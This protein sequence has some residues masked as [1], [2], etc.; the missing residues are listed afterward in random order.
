MNVLTRITKPKPS[1]AGLK[2]VLVQ[3]S[4]LLLWGCGG[5]SGIDIGSGQSADAVVL[6]YPLFYVKRPVSVDETGQQIQPD[7]RELLSVEFGADLF[8][9]ERA[10]V[11]APEINLSSTI[12]EELHDVRDISVSH[13]GNLVL[14]S[15]R[16]PVDP[17][18]DE[19]DQPAWNIWEYDVQ[20]RSM[21]RIM[22]DDITA[23][24]GHDIGAQ[25]LPNGR[26]VF[27]STRQN[28]SVAR[29]TDQGKPQFAAL[30]EDQN[31]PAFVLHVMDADGTNIE[32]ISFNQSHDS[33][34]TVLDNG[35]I[36][37]SR[38]DGMGNRS[39]V[40]L[41]TANPDGTDL[42]LLYG[43]DSHETASDGMIQ[44]L[45]PKELPD[46]RVLSL[47]A[48]FSG[49]GGG[50][51]LVI[52]DVADYL[53]NTQPNKFNAGATGPAERPATNQ[54]VFVMP[55]VS[56]GG[57]FLSA[58]P[59]W[60]GTSRALISYS[61]CRVRVPPATDAEICDET[62]ILDPL[63]EDAIPAYG[64]WVVDLA[65][66]SIS[67]ILQP[68]DGFTISHIA[69]AQNRPRQ[70]DILDQDASGLSDPMLS[71]ERAGILQIRSVYDFDGSDPFGYAALA[72][73]AITNANERPARFIRI[74]SAV[75]IPDED[76]LDLDNSAF[77]I[78]RA[79]GMRE[80]IGYAPI[81]PDGS[82][83]VKVPADVPIS[84]DVL[85]AR[86]KRIFPFARH[87]NWLQLRPGE[88]RECSG[89]H[90]PGLPGI[91]HG[92]SDAFD[93]VNVGAPVTGYVFPN[94]ALGTSAELGET[95]AANRL[96]QS[97]FTDCAVR[98]LTANLVYQDVWTA[99][100]L[101]PATSFELGYDGLSVAG[102]SV[103]PGL[104]T[105]VPERSDCV[106]WTVDCRITINY[107]QHIQPLWELERAA[108][109]PD[110]ASTVNRCID[111]H[112]LRDRGGLLIDP[113]TGRGQLELTRNASDQDPNHF[114]SYRELLSADNQELLSGDT[115]AVQD[116]LADALD[117]DG[118]PVLEPV[119]I[120]SPLSV[121]GA[122]ATPEFFSRFTEPGSH[123]GYLSAAELHLITEWLDLGAQYF[124]DPF[125]EGVPVN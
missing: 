36:M 85:D 89:C 62:N 50:G 120:S 49:T 40:S 21:R 23:D 19:A 78:R 74:Y 102:A 100:E 88:V 31:E 45:K 12:T 63:A 95:M 99:P 47:I 90:D 53:N 101:T 18:A 107:E 110:P 69:I 6:D 26:I 27:A 42:Q 121:A 51:D 15:M 3:L 70:N 77:G 82:V 33:D 94:T 108:I 14:F 59:L 106:P 114:K 80:I 87:L 28:Q 81:E 35:R 67:P 56:E 4:L 54:P 113:E 109:D 37:F 76:T 65:D 83:I 55:G 105:A 115:G 29:L 52:I 75:G 118:N 57:R 2:I 92:R 24:E 13:D 8:M 10:A 73:P 64:I 98:D 46:G 122:A 30:D 58:W 96:R 86:G 112:A 5:D 104:Q 71:Q 7:Y 60:D 48:P 91:S 38:W 103:E 17:D 119:E 41:Y 34:P 72:D 111:C 16:F 11:G 66:G 84:I 68:E 116:F 25:Y 22:E 61:L 124:N 117:D 32:Q 123:Q 44:F 93:A 125:A 20:A 39:A 9:R 79:N 97:C 43:A 1:G